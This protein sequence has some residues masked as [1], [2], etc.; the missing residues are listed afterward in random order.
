MEGPALPLVLS[1]R[2]SRAAA[3]N[4][5]APPI[6]L[7]LRARKV[8][9]CPTQS[10][11]PMG[12][13]PPGS[14]VHG[15]LRV[16]I[17]VWVAMPSSRA[18]SQPRDRTHVSLIASRFFTSWAMREA[19]GHVNICIKNCKKVFK[20]RKKLPFCLYALDCWKPFHFSTTIFQ[21]PFRAH[22][23]SSERFI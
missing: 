13:G 9:S 21:I 3:V 7:L 16:R 12:W 1:P 11:D 17:L 19:R 6:D 8:K 20:K 2:L 10:C 18:S 23:G 15:I 22:F 14:S 5:G 4:R